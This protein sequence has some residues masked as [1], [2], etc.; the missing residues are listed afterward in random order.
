[1]TRNS[2]LE[3]TGEFGEFSTDGAAISLEEGIAPPLYILP[4]KGAS[5]IRVRGAVH[6][7]VHDLANSS[8]GVKGQPVC[9][10]GSASGKV[11]RGVTHGRLGLMDEPKVESESGEVESWYPYN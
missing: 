11:V 7:E 4:N 8:A 1:M 10:S 6:E 5:L 2:Y 3:T 9:M